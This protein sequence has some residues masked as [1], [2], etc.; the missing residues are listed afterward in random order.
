VLCAAILAEYALRRDL[1][2]DQLLVRA[3]AS[4]AVRFPGRP[5]PH[6]AASLILIGTALATLDLRPWRKRPAPALAATAGVIAMIAILGHLFHA[7]EAYGT[8]SF[9]PHNEM[10][11]ISAVIIMILSAGCLA[12]RPDWGALATVMSPGAGGIA[13]RR[14]LLGLLAMGPLVVL[15]AIFSQVGWY[16]AE[17]AA[18]FIVF[19]GFFEAVAFVLRTA[20]HLNRLDR[21][22]QEIQRLRNE[23]IG[24]TSHELRN[25]L[26]M[27]LVCV[28]QLRDETE[29]LSDQGREVLAILDRSVRRMARLVEDFLDVEK[30]ESGEVKLR[31]KLVELGPLIAETIAGISGGAG[32]VVLQASEGLTVKGDRDRLTQVVIN[33]ISNAL[34]FSPAGGR[35]EVDAQRRDGKARVS[36]RDR[37]PGIPSE[38]Q[39][40]IFLRF[41]RADKAKTHGSGLGLYISRAI[42]EK[43]GGRI[44]FETSDRGTTFFFE[45]PAAA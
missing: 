19:L 13:A 35:V 7:E 6:T 39:K 21:A 17:T 24:M 26:T 44:G 33:L 22:Q 29:Q 3:A 1:G 2:I 9:F 25:P 10:A 32:R 38:F 28:S 45:L 4:P 5:S 37:G 16:S 18:G 43:H 14:M 41:A 31:L 23:V 8:A 27:A 40:H 34:K 15:L 42:V 20:E 11:F 12:A 30:L 36:V